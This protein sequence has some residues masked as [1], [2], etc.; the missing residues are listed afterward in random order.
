[1]FEMKITYLGDAFQ[2][3]ENDVLFTSNSKKINLLFKDTSVVFCFSRTIRSSDAH[4]KWK[5]DEWKSFTHY[6]LL[7]YL[8]SFLPKIKKKNTFSD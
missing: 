6:L 4:E 5:C 1:M 2:L 3:E 8:D 7:P